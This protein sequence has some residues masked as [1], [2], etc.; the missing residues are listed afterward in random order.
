[1]NASSDANCPD[2]T[3]TTTP[4]PNYNNMENLHRVGS[5]S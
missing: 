2:Y 5:H 1:M 3:L 4:S